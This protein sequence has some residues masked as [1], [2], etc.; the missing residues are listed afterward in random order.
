MIIYVDG[1]AC[2]VTNEI[3]SIANQRL[4]KVIVLKSYS[5]YSYRQHLGFV[6]EIYLDSESEA[7]DYKLISLVK[8]NDLVITQDYGLASLALQKKCQVIHPRGF[9]FTERNIDRLLASR[10]Q[11]AQIRKSGG[12]TK[13]PAPFTEKSRQQFVDTF[14]ELIL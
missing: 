13:G 10:Y 3:I 14:T 5:H 8:A 2:P 4:I 1:D 7:V 12:R 6:E 11:N 9:I